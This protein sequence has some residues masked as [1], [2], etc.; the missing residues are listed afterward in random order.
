MVVC[1]FEESP[2]HFMER[3]LE[4]N[5][6]KSKQIDNKTIKEFRKNWAC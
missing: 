3:S 2:G 4:R 6:H 1:M 5:E